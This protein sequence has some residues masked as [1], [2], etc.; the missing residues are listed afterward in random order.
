MPP[1]RDEEDSEE[2]ASSATPTPRTSLLLVP[3]AEKEKAEAEAEAEPSQASGSRPASPATTEEEKAEEDAVGRPPPAAADDE[4][5]AAV[6][7]H[8]RAS[9]T[10]TTMTTQPAADAHPTKETPADSVDL[11]S[12]GVG[13]ALRNFY[14]LKT[15]EDARHLHKTLGVLC[16][17]HYVYRFACA[18]LLGTMRFEDDSPRAFF[19]WVALHG[20]L[21]WSSFL[22]HL[23]SKRN[24]HKPIIWPELRFHNCVF[25]TRSLLDAVLHGAGLGGVWALRVALVFATMLAADA[26]T[27]HYKRR[28]LL[29]GDDSTMRGMPFPDGVLPA[30]RRRM[31]LYYGASQL[32]ATAGTLNVS[33]RWA[34]DV[35]LAFTTLFA[36]QLSALLMT[37]VRKSILKPAGWHFWYAASLGMSWVWA[38]VRYGQTS[39]PTAFV[40]KT[41]L[42]VAVLMALRFRANVDKYALWTALAVADVMLQSKGYDDHPWGVDRAPAVNALVERAAAAAGADALVADV[43]AW[44]HASRRQV[45]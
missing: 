7:R 12:W 35:E 43:A 3:G 13:L 23:P 42:T 11:E 25:A 45:W 27:N 21:S 16:L 40:A 29:E 17:L 19:A 14:K 9:A 10:L 32:L 37:L 22:F 6:L 30:S 34:V 44:F 8:R 28:A 24:K 31:N 4:G 1:T 33:R 38:T 36:I 15:P 20:L 41:V 18:A 5:Y 39:S 2:K 26:V